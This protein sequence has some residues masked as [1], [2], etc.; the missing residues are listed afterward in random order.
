MKFLPLFQ[1]ATI[2]NSQDPYETEI[3]NE[4]CLINLYMIIGISNL[5]F[6]SIEST[7]MCILPI[8][9]FETRLLTSEHLK[10]FSWWLLDRNE[11][12]WKTRFW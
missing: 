3:H 11:A 4:I 12:M 7:K 2:L 5:N 10:L 8:F 1:I 9:H 6:W